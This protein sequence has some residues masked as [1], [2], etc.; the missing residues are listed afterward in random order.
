MT[1]NS[2]LLLCQ[3]NTLADCLESSALSA[4]RHSFDVCDDLR[5]LDPR[6]ARG[7]HVALDV[8]HVDRARSDALHEVAVGVDTHLLQLLGQHVQ[9]RRLDARDLAQNPLP[10]VH[11]LLAL[12]NRQDA[13]CSTRRFRH[14]SLDHLHALHS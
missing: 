10:N 4:H 11:G 1:T 6:D 2:D 12:W 13:R 5:R 8:R 9:R 14:S 3:S 7:V